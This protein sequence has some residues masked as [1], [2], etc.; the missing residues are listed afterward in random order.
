MN[1]V[2]P[3]T[4]KKLGEGGQGQVV[5]LYSNICGSCVLKTPLNDARS[6]EALVR[7]AGIM[8]RIFCGDNLLPLLQSGITPWGQPFVLLP[9]CDFSLSEL[10]NK[11]GTH[12]EAWTVLYIALHVITGLMCLHI[13]KLVHCDLKPDSILVSTCKIFSK[14]STENE[15]RPPVT[16]DRCLIADFGMTVDE[17]AKV[18]GYTEGYFPPEGYKCGTATTALDVYALGVILWNLA[19]GEVSVCLRTYFVSFFL[20]KAACLI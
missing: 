5:Q 10:L 14:A 12:L 8:A 3:S 4:F 20:D 16:G 9:Q 6:E 19:T 18:L 2:V 11:E 15:V 7:E 1:L 17:G 13:Q